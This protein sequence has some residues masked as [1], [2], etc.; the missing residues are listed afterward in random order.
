MEV[1]SKKESG[2]FHVYFTVIT[3]TSCSLLGAQPRSMKEGVDLVNLGMDLDLV[4]LGMRFS[5]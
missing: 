5:W 4:N 1:Y 2:M 3:Q